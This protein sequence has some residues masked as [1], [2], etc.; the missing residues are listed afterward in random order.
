ML[1]MVLLL[2]LIRA[3]KHIENLEIPR[4]VTSAVEPTAEWPEKD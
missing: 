3:P 1:T 4:L 2:E